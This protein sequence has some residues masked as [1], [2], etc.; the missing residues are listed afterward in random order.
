MKTEQ[1]QVLGVKLS[2]RAAVSR[3]TVAVRINIRLVLP[4]WLCYNV[5]WLAAFHNTYAVPSQHSRY[6]SSLPYSASCFS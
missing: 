6:V 1:S 3:C 5:K 2:Y 4:H